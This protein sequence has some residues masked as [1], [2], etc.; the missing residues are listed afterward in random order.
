MIPLRVIRVTMRHLMNKI[1]LVILILVCLFGC[2]KEVIKYTIIKNPLLQ[3]VPPDTGIYWDRWSQM[4]GS[5]GAYNFSVGLFIQSLD[6]AP[7]SSIWI[8]GSFVTDVTF[9]GS[10]WSSRCYNNL[11]I[12]SPSFGRY[13]TL[14]EHK[15]KI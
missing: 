9:A 11:S 5:S 1:S 6:I 12:Q 2:K 8:L 14:S 4:V 3:P 15:P 10:L 7:D 13:L